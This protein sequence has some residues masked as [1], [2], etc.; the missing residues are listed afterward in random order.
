MPLK[1][2][3]LIVLLSLN[4]QLDRTPLHA[5]AMGN[6]VEVG[7]LLIAKGADVDA[8]DQVSLRL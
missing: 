2:S 3:E 1:Q 4:L 8:G 7:K 5:S 6:H